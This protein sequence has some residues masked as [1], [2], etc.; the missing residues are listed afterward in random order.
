MKTQKVDTSGTEAAN[1]A[2]AAA[3]QASANLQKNFAADLQTENLTQVVA[4]GTATAADTSSTSGRRRR[5]GSGSLSSQL[6]I[7]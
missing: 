4:G 3:Q 7:Y 1:R 5:S 6:G 2:V